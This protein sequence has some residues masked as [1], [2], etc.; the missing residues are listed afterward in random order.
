MNL[1]WKRRKKN[2]KETLFEPIKRSKRNYPFFF[3][4]VKKKIVKKK[5]KEQ[6]YLNCYLD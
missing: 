2:K 3:L 5:K 1:D 4:R 6:R